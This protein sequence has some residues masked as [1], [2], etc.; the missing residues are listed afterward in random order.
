MLEEGL[1]LAERQPALLRP[2]DRRFRV[3]LLVPDC[4]VVGDE[5]LGDLGEKSVIIVQ[6]FTIGSTL[7]AMGRIPDGV[8]KLEAVYPELALL[9]I[10]R[11][12]VP[13]QQCKYL[14]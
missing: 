6:K 7:S 5:H 1:R 3:F 14:S 12:P 4:V 10:H 8:K 11:Q 9:A 2:D 13:S